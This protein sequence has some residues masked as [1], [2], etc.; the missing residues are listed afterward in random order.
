VSKTTGKLVSFLGEYFMKVL[1][2]SV[3]LIALNEICFGIPNDG[4]HKHVPS[5]GIIAAHE[6]VKDSAIM[7]GPVDHKFDPVAL[8]LDTLKNDRSESLSKT[9][10]AICFQKA[11]VGEMYIEACCKG[12]EN[13]RITAQRLIEHGFGSGADRSAALQWAAGTGHEEALLLLL[14]PEQEILS[15]EILEV[16]DNYLLRMAALFGLTKAV[17]CLLDYPSTWGNVNAIHAEDDAA[18]RNAA[19]RGFGDI[20][21]MLVKHGANIYVFDDQALRKAVESGHVDMVRFLLENGANAA[22]LDNESLKFV[23]VQLVRNDLENS[24][25]EAYTK[26]AL[27]LRKH[28]ASVAEEVVVP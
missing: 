10:Y 21:K 19:T 23:T 27:L 13:S 25:K 22:A 8:L 26:I 12:T 3:G 7:Q 16:N 14:N 1:W 20:V 28:G 17:K 24:K 4:Y 9:A 2:I 11:P 5:L 6:V 18:L 15:A